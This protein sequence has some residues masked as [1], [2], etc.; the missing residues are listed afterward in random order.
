MGKATGNI[1]QKPIAVKLNKE[2]IHGLD[3]FVEKGGYNGRSHAVREMILPYI[4]SALEVEKTK[5]AWAGY[6][7]YATQAAGMIERL[8]SVHKTQAEAAQTS[9]PLDIQVQPT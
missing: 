3:I 8:N 6:K 7:A 4:V 9:L 5:S 2:Q 1:S